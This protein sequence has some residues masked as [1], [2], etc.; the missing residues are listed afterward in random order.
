[1]TANRRKFLQG[2]GASLAIL[3]VAGQGAFAAVGVAAKSPNGKSLAGVFP[4]GWTP[5]KPDNSFDAEAM[6]KQQQ[7]LNRGK[8]AGMA[9][10]QNAS[11][12]Q[13]LTQAV[14]LHACRVSICRRR[15]LTPLRS[16]RLW[17][18]ETLCCAVLRAATAA[19]PSTPC[20]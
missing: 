7:F 1:M 8:V 15:R 13:S 20:R 12:W 3:A 19:R 17:G 2:T 4:I 6:V 10:P 11:G 9:W 5:C 16:S 18:V 14:S